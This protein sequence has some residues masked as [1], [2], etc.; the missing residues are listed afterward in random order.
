MK[1]KKGEQVMRWNRKQRLLEKDLEE[2]GNRYYYICDALRVSPDIVKSNII[3][4]INY[5]RKWII[6]SSDNKLKALLD[7][8]KEIVNNQ[9]KLK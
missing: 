6:S 3:N 5:Y 8:A 2:A 9:W 1:V 7:N 4:K